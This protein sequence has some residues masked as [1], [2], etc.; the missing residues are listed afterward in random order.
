MNASKPLIKGERRYPCGFPGCKWIFTRSNHVIRHHQRVH[1]GFNPTERPTSITK[2]VKNSSNNVNHQM[3]NSP[4]NQSVQVRKPS[5]ATSVPLTASSASPLPLQS[6]FVQSQIKS[7]SINSSNHA[8]SMLINSCSSFNNPPSSS[9]LLLQVMKQ[10]CS[11]LNKNTESTKGYGK[12]SSNNSLI[13]SNQQL[14]NQLVQH[15]NP[16]AAGQMKVG[17]KES[18]L[19]SSSCNEMFKCDHMNCGQMFLTISSLTNHKRLSHSL[20]DVDD[21]NTLKECLLQSNVVTPSNGTNKQIPLFL[22]SPTLS[23]VNH[24][25]SQLNHPHHNHHHHNRSL[26]NIDHSSSSLTNASLNLLRQLSNLGNQDQSDSIRQQLIQSGLINPALIN[27]NLKVEN[28]EDDN[29]SSNSNNNNPSILDLV[30]PKPHSCP[31]DSC[32]K[33]FTRRDH[34]KRHILNF[35][36]GSQANHPSP[37]ESPSS[38]ELNLSIQDMVPTSSGSQGNGIQ[39]H[40]QQQQS[41]EQQV[42][43]PGTVPSPACSIPYVDM[44]PEVVLEVDESKIWIDPNQNMTSDFPSS[45]SRTLSDDVKSLPIRKRLKQE[46]SI[47]SIVIEE[48]DDV[49]N[50]SNNSSNGPSL[51]SSSFIDSTQ[52]NQQ[53]SVF[54]SRFSFATSPQVSFRGKRPYMCDIGHCTKSYTKHSHLVRHKVETHK[55]K[56]PEPRIRPNNATINKPNPVHHTTLPPPPINLQERPYLCDFPGCKW[57]FKRQ[58]HLDRHFMTHRQQQLNNGAT[59]T[60][61]KEEDSPMEQDHDS[62]PDQS[63]HLLNLSLAPSPKRKLQEQPQFMGLGTSSILSPSPSPHLVSSPSSGNQQKF[64]WN[65]VR[66]G[67]DKSKV[68]SVFKC[69]H[70][71]N[72]GSDCGLTFNSQHAL[73]MHEYFVHSIAP[74]SPK[75]SVGRSSPCVNGQQANGGNTVTQNQ[76]TASVQGPKI[77]VPSF[78]KSPPKTA[79]KTLS[80]FSILAAAAADKGTKNGIKSESIEVEQDND[81]QKM[82]DDL[83]YILSLRNILKSMEEQQSNI[84]NVQQQVSGQTNIE[85]DDEQMEEEFIDPGASEND[86]DVLK[87]NQISLQQLQQIILMNTLLNGSSNQANNQ[88]IASLIGTMGNNANQILGGNG[89]PAV[90][91]NIVRNIVRRPNTVTSSRPLESNQQIDKRK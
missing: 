8:D 38:G 2:G 67:P 69:S 5:V 42:S 46:T 78:F 28:V 24:S 17:G 59:S 10:Q 56:K 66:I 27:S 18:P 87:N 48:E 88:L 71:Q 22:N 86:G 20:N 65:K 15:H 25:S 85:E 82:S 35:H 34:L 52:S 58:Y 72:Q 12:N 16:T 63:S 91:S 54:P 36:V 68:D 19:S 41:R 1:P 61:S 43:T 40:Y 39:Q 81:G 45:S 53:L 9:S 47:G 31:F 50:C 37:P 33:S 3:F 84:Q 7:S 73:Q 29:G 14:V 32:G 57:S 51:F 60:T 76:S 90:N 49:N 79:S 4:G 83:M 11:G 77:K 64:D 55:M 89:Q 21:K 70:K 44:E 23:N 80:E 75:S 30:L 62:E 74:R 26:S 13:S 6:S